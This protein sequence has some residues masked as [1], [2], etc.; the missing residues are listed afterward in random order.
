EF[1]P[2]SGP[3]DTPSWVDISDR[4]L[5]LEWTV[6]TQQDLE[7][8]PPGEATVVLRNDDRLFDPDHTAGTYFGQLLPRVP[9]RVRA[10]ADDPVTVDGEFV[11]VGG[12]LLTVGSSTFDCF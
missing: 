12:E 1:S 10:T 7:D 6:G 5:S 9:F 8:Y 11:Y 2:G 4:V 3:F